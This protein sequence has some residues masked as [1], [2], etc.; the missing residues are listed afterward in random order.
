MYIATIFDAEY[1]DIE[2]AS[3]AE[4]FDDAVAFVFDKIGN[5]PAF[6]VETSRDGRSFSLEV[7]DGKSIRATVLDQEPVNTA[8]QHPLV[9]QII[10]ACNELASGDGG[11]AIRALFTGAV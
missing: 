8:S 10:N 2:T 5:N 9:K 4:C 3:P 6:S 11:S 7:K 1:G